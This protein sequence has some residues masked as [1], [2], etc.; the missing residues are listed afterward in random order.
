MSNRLLRARPSPTPSAKALSARVL[1]T[2]FP[3]CH[4]HFYRFI[5]GDFLNGFYCFIIGALNCS[6]LQS[7]T[8]SGSH[9]LTVGNFLNGVHQLTVANPAWLSPVDN[10]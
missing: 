9:R 1:K 3:L 6:V 10:R 4:F 5:T 2:S 8:L 7:A